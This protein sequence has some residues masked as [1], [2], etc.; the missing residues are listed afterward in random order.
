MTVASFVFGDFVLY[1][2]PPGCGGPL[3]M[4]VEMTAEE[5]EQL[6]HAL[7]IAAARVREKRIQ[8]TTRP[9]PLEE[10]FALDDLAAPSAVEKQPHAVI[11]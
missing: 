4:P 9:L 11:V 8:P 3:D 1:E 2:I 5:A 10:D 6:A 7:I